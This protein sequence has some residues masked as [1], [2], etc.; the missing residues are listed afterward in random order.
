MSF[1][2]T[3]GVLLRRQP[4]REGRALAESAAYFDVAPVGARHLACDGEAQTHAARRPRCVHSVKLIKDAGQVLGGNAGAG[5]GDRHRQGV[6][7]PPLGEVSPEPSKTT[8][9]GRNSGMAYSWKIFSPARMG[10]FSRFSR[11][12]M[13]HE[14]FSLYAQKG[15]Y[16][17]LKSTRNLPLPSGSGSR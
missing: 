5:V 7:D 15:L 6:I 14:K 17:K 10:T 16:A 1:H 13:G 3:S 8:N 12:V 9:P 2:E 11:G 4:Y